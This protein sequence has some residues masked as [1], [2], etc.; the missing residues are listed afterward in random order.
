MK[1]VCVPVWKAVVLAIAVRVMGDRLVAGDVFET[2]YQYY[3][4]GNGRMRVDSIHSLF[5][6][7]AG[8]NV[9]I[10]GT[11]LYSTLSGAS[12]TGLPLSISADGRIDT[13]HLRDERNAFS[14][15]VNR[16]YGNHVLRTGIAYS[17]ESD[18]LSYAYS[19]QDTISFNQKN[20][21]L[22]AGY[23]FTDDTVGANGSDLNASKR[24][25]AALLGL[26]QILGPDDLLSVNLTCTWRD[27]Y[28]SD[29]YKRFWLN[30][31][32]EVRWDNR[33][34]RRSE[35]M[36]QVRW[37]HRVASL[38]GS[39]ETTY[40]FGVSDWGNDSHMMRVTFHKKFLDGRM[41]VSPGIRY[42]RQSAATFYDTEFYG[43]PRY[44]SADYRLAAEETWSGGLQAR[45][46]AVPDR[47]AF[48]VGWERYITRGLD[49]KTPQGM[50]PSA[51]TVSVGVHLDF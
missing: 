4:E 5:S 51:T 45:W 23:S 12:P 1:R 44:S 39:V 46:Y 19:I 34:S 13:I 8:K 16:V 48:D 6:V 29:P 3:Q 31:L 40:R 38:G 37:T 33:P 2:R 32:S 36:L 11:Y 15:G 43:S 27:G 49:G 7:E 17:Q 24:S 42:Y 18:Y 21:E 41:I 22:V 47:L 25:H 28:L 26:S 9:S 14:L 10:D 50:F 30:D 20:T 35:Q